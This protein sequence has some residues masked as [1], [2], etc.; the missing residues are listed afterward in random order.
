MFVVTDDVIE[1]C[2]ETFFSEIVTGFSITAEEE[3]EPEL[4]AVEAATAVFGVDSKTGLLLDLFIFSCT[5]LVEAEDLGDSCVDPM[6]PVDA[7][8]RSVSK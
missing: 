8:C 3:P 7:R 1:S 4:E 6:L 2:L 5:G